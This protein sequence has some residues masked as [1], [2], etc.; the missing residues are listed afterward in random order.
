MR[1]HLQNGYHNSRNN[2][3]YFLATIAAY[4]YNDQGHIMKPFR[5]GMVNC[6]VSAMGLDRHM[7]LLRPASLSAAELGK[8]HSE[9]YLERLQHLKP[10][11]EVS[12]TDIETFGLG[13]TDNPAFKG[14]FDFSAL[15]AGASVACAVEL[16][17]GNSDIVLNWAGGLH[18]ARKGKA[19]GFCPANDIVLGTTELM[20]RHGRV[21]Y[22]DIDVHHGDGVENAFYGTNRV[23]TV[24]FHKYGEKFFPET[25]SLNDIGAGIG[26]NYAINVPLNDGITDDSFFDLF[27]KIVDPL[28][29]RFQPNAIVMQ[30]GADSLAGDLVGPFNLSTVGHGRCVDHI[31]RK[32]LPLM[33]LGGGGYNRGQRRSLLC[34]RYS[35]R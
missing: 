27:K 4:K 6:L 26:L 35:H 16:N 2:L 13:G 30:C 18:H 34:Q 10:D 21:L 19:A 23:A 28:M 12:V 1:L 9:S 29:L 7:T 33:L 25:G 8:F 5:I 17:L 15:A 32:N 31:K 14:I 11:E 24:S 20:K 3:F 22:V